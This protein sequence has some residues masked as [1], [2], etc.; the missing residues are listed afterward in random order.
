[1]ASAALLLLDHAAPAPARTDRFLSKTSLTS[2]RWRALAIS[3]VS[4]V[5]PLEVTPPLPCPKGAVVKTLFSSRFRHCHAVRGADRTPHAAS[6]CRT[7]RLSD[8]RQKSQNGTSHSSPCPTPRI[9]SKVFRIRNFNQLINCLIV[10][11]VF[12]TQ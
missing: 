1:M 12:P 6:R 4:L 10:K 2:L 11:P 8:R 9:I 3:L 7:G 5:F